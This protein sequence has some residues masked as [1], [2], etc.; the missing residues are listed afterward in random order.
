MKE[1]IFLF[2]FNH[3]ERTGDEILVKVPYEIADERDFALIHAGI[4]FRELMYLSKYKNVK[5]MKV[6]EQ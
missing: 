5:I 1:Y 3:S 4:I 6:Y 2:V